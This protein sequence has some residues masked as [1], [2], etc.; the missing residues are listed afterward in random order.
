MRRWPWTRRWT[1]GED[2]RR[3]AMEHLKETNAR[4]PEVNAVAASLRDLRQRNHFAEQL[5]YILR[6]EGK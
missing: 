1:G 4:W 2:A 6:N 3:E 5:Q